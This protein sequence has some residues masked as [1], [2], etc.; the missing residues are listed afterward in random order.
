MSALRAQRRIKLESPPIEIEDAALAM[1]KA[2]ELK[3]QLEAW[4]IDAALMAMAQQASDKSA[5]RGD[6]ELAKNLFE[7]AKEAARS[8]EEKATLLAMRVEMLV[9][10]AEHPD[11]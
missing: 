2:D 1:I 8:H 9:Y 6:Q 5:L 11:E 3:Q 10:Q 7:V 4:Q